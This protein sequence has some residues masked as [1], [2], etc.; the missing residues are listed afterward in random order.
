MIFNVPVTL[1][2]YTPVLNW[3]FRMFEDHDEIGTESQ[4]HNKIKY[5]IKLYKEGENTTKLAHDLAEMECWQTRTIAISDY[6]IPEYWDPLHET[7]LQF[8]TRMSGRTIKT[9]DLIG[10]NPP[11]DILYTHIIAVLK[12]RHHHYLDNTDQ[13][14]KTKYAHKPNYYD[15]LSQHDTDLDDT[16]LDPSDE[17]NGV[18]DDAK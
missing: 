5:L 16:D 12:I 15:T 1:T 11:R 13:S 10:S 17:F 6:Q 7:Y 8:K 18:N 14:F 3:L 4:L 9:F 2:H